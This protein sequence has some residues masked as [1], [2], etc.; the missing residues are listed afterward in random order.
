MSK[1]A[2]CSGSDQT[3]RRCF[4]SSA[5]SHAQTCAR[6]L[7]SAGRRLRVCDLAV[8]LKVQLLFPAHPETSLNRELGLL[9]PLT[10]D[11]QVEADELFFRLSDDLMCFGRLVC[12]LRFGSFSRLRPPVQT[13]FILISSLGLERVMERRRG[14][15][16]EWL[17]SGRFRPAEGSKERGGARQ[18][19]S[20]E[21][22]QT[23]TVVSEEADQREEVKSVISTV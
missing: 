10:S 5:V 17:W 6:V 11:L 14:G 19:G 9:S 12:F 3:S 8:V 18:G 16:G 13:S 4:L 22:L 20:A 21:N 1:A 2:G 15:G 7:L 23:L